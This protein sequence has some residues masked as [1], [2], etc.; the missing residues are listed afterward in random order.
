MPGDPEDFD[1][2]EWD[3]EKSDATYEERGIDFEFAAR[4]FDGDY[5]E[6]ED[7]G[8]DYGERRFV[9]TGE[10]DGFVVTLVWTPAAGG[11]G[12]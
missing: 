1:G 5:I 8:R 2:F 3:P 10:V 6:R 9:V 11:G 7:L 4:A 12:S